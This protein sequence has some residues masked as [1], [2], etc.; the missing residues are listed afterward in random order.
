[1]TQASS[2]AGTVAARGPV[3]G[4]NPDLAPAMVGM[5][6][7]LLAARRVAE[8]SGA[9][10][11]VTAPRCCPRFTKKA[12]VA[13]AGAVPIPSTTA[14]SLPFSLIKMGTSPPNEKCENSITEAARIVATPASTALP[15]R[16]R[17]RIPASTES[18]CPPATTPRRP[19]TTGRNVS[20]LETRRFAPNT[21]NAIAIER[22]QRNER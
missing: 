4:I 10:A 9:V 17:I 22:Q 12:R 1:M 14:T 2:T 13:F 3:E 7:L 8:E 18:G 15:P 16:C 11:V 5:S 19:R 20:A 6:A 21:A